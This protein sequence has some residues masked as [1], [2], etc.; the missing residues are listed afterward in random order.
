[1]YFTIH[2]VALMFFCSDLFATDLLC[3]D[4]KN[5]D[6]CEG[7]YYVNL[8]MYCLWRIDDPP[9]C[10][11]GYWD[12]CGHFGLDYC[13]LYPYCILRDDK[14]VLDAPCYF[15]ES[16]NESE[17]I[18]PDSCVM[19]TIHDYNASGYYDFY[20]CTSEKNKNPNSCYFL[21]YYEY[22][23]DTNTYIYDEN[24][25]ENQTG[26]KSITINSEEVKGNYCVEIEKE[27]EIEEEEEDDDSSKTS[28]TLSF[29][30]FILVMVFVI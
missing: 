7:T 3:D 19:H 6:V 17:L 12:I 4:L 20:L 14:C 1:M 28:Y 10:V 24:V 25:C 15:T 8:E 9:H 18:C 26:C 27:R 11:Y 29:F 5:Q 23:N 2:G 16:M 13:H 30:I 22:E 21:S